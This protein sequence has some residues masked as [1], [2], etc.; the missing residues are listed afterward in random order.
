M[1]HRDKPRRRSKR[2]KFGDKGQRRAFEAGARGPET[3][4]DRLVQ[5]VAE[6]IGARKPRRRKKKIR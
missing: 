6:T 2:V 3:A 5:K 1:P 4:L